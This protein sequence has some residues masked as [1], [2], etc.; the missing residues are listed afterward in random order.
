MLFETE[1]TEEKIIAATFDILERKV[2]K[3]LRLKK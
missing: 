1:S 3:K 2:Y